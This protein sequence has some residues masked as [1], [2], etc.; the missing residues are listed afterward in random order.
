MI[1]DDAK[2][3]LEIAIYHALCRIHEINT[4]HEVKSNS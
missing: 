3:F 4:L 1:S 2:H